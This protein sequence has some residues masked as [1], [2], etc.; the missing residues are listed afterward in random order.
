MSSGT[1]RRWLLAA[2]IALGVVPV[3]SAQAGLY[4]SLQASVEPLPNCVPAVQGQTQPIIWDITA[5]GLMACT[6]P[7]TWSPIAVTHWSIDSS[8]DFIPISAG[9]QNIGSNS[10]PI[11]NLYING[12]IVNTTIA[13]WVW[14]GVEGSCGATQTG[15]DILCIGA[16]TTSG[17]AVNGMRESINNSASF[18]VPV[19]SVGLES[20]GAGVT[21]CSDGGGNLASC[22]LNS[23]PYSTTPALNPSLGLVQQFSCTTASA[24][25]TPTF[26]VPPAGTI[27]TVVFVQNGTT[28]CTWTWPT[29]IH[30]ATAVSS[31][32]SSISTQQFVVSNNG[33]DAYAVAAG[34]STTGGTP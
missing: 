22:G 10:L 33:T 21:T 31:T 32:L 24:S 2:V 12:S 27:F 4:T 17:Y 3:A 20:S 34:T 23:I 25:I 16:S 26:V 13:P 11:G 19:E 18:H 29:H 28:A 1:I 5:E 14:N 30:G 8:G 6:G 7:N 15:H 9:T